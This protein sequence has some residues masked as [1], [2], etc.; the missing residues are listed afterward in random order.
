M[1]PNVFNPN[2]KAAIVDR[3]NALTPQSQRQWGTMSV[4]QMLNHLQRPIQ[5]SLGELSSKKAAPSWVG[6]LAKI[7]FLGGIK[8]PKNTVTMKEFK[9]RTD[10]YNFDTEK[11]AVLTYLQKAE[12]TANTSRLK[13]H[14]LFGNLSATEWGQLTYI[15][16]DHHLRQFGV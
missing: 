13:A 1:K 9:V 5:H 14:P 6:W 12:E 3:L 10:D 16:L 7:V 11:Q 15:H 4:S 2:D 8:F